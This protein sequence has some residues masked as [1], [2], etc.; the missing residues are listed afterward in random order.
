VKRDVFDLSQGGGRKCRKEKTEK[1]VI[2][3]MDG[4]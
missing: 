3:L 4:K 2:G 1:Y